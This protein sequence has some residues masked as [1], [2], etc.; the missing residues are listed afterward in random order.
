MRP[1]PA[2]QPNY[3]LETLRALRAG[4]PEGGRLFCLM[5]ADSFASL[6]RWRGAAEIPFAASPRRGFPS[7]PGTRRPG[8]LPAP[9]PDPGT[10]KRRGPGP[11]ATAPMPAWS[12]VPTCCAIPPAKPRPFYLLP[13]LDVEISASADPRPGPL[14]FPR[15]RRSPLSSRARRRLHPLP[16]S[17]PL[18]RVDIVPESPTQTTTSA[19]P[20]RCHPDVARSAAEGPAVALV[21]G[22]QSMHGAGAALIR[23]SRSRFGKRPGTFPV[24]AISSQVISKSSAKDVFRVA[25]LPGGA[26]A[27]ANLFRRPAVACP[28][29]RCEADPI[30]DP[31]SSPSRVPGPTPVRA[32]TRPG[33]DPG[34]GFGRLHCNRRAVSPQR[35]QIRALAAVDDQIALAGWTVPAGPCP[36]REPSQAVGAGR[37]S[38][39]ALETPR[40]RSRSVELRPILDTADLP[41]VGGFRRPRSLA[42]LAFQ[43]PA[44]SIAA[45]CTSNGFEPP[46]PGFR[47]NPWPAPAGLPPDGRKSP[48]RGGR[49]GR[50]EVVRPN[51]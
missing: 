36:S 33:R 35:R 4:L 40:R 6:G 27:D 39:R 9:G 20:K 44:D 30:S 26:F 11:A 46:G 8:P 34:C 41:A 32:T 12:F 21:R 5:G 15:R 29:P 43:Q 3:T 50:E 45:C 31:T 2:G 37:R 14:G 16:P 48:P 18:A 28:C 47:L 7:R 51:S 25:D 19:I 49:A 23:P 13:G 17:L 1:T 10:G 24:F 22:F 38:S 42:G